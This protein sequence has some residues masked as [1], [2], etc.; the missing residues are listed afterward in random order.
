MALAS[1]TSTPTKPLLILVD[2]HSLAFRSYFAFAKGRDGGL[3]T[4]TGIPTSVSYGF[5]KALLETM[6]TEKPQYVA[7]AFD[8]G[9]KTF[10][11]EADETYKEGR[12][13][14]PED[15]MP[16]LENLQELLTALNLQILTMPR[17]EADDIIG[18]LVRKATANGFR[19]KILTGDRDLFQLIDPDQNTSVL[20]MSTTYGK[21]TPPPREF[22]AEQVKEKLGVLP[23][24]VVDFKALCGDASDNI[25]GVK[26]IGEKTAVQLLSEYGSLE[27]IYASLDQVKGAVRKKLEEGRDDALRSQYLAQIHLDVP[28]EI[29]LEAFK[30]QEMNDAAVIPLLE[31]LEFN[32][33]LNR[34][35]Q[36]HRQFDGNLTEASETNAPSAKSVRE[37]PDLWFFSAADTEAAQ[38]EVPV[39][40]APQ[41]IDTPA[42]LT[43]LIQRLKTFTNPDTPVSWDTETTALEP[44]DADLV[45]IGCCWG[46]ELSD[47]AYIP[48]GHTKGTNLDKATAL[49]ALRPILES[50]DYPK[51]LQNAKF[52]RLV[53]RCQ[54]IKL[55]GV[56]FD[57]MLASYVLNPESRHNLSDLSSA[58]L[59]ITAM[60]YT[61]LV[62]KGKAMADI[63][64]PA[65]A[66]YC[67]LDVYT[68]FLLVAKLRAKLEEVPTL[69]RL[70]LEVE[71]PLEP[72]LAEM[73]YCGVLI[74]R[75][76]L[77]HFS[78]QLEQDLHA[79]EQRAY[80]AAG[81]TFNLGSPKQ[82]SELLFETL[83]LD[84]KKSRK[85]AS[86]GYSTDAQTLER[87]EGDHPIIEEIVEYRTLSK[88]KSTYVDALPALIRPDTGRVHTD[89]NQAIASTGRLSSSDPNLQNIPIR[90]E[91]S[92]Q[93]RKAFIAEPEWVMVSADY[94]QIELRILAHLS[95]EPVLLET[96]QNN[97]DVHTLTARLLLEKENISSEE[98]RLA[99]IINFGVIY[100]MGAQRFA[101]ESGMKQADAKTFIER[102]NERYSNVFKYLQQMQREAIANGYVETILGRRRYFDFGSES[103]RKLR[104][105]KPDTIDLSKVKVRDQYD[106]Q[107]LRAAAN[108]PIQGSSADIIK[109]A[110]NQLHELI[111]DRQARLLLQVHDEL[112]FEMPPQ[113]WE[114]L[115]TEIKSTMESAVELTVPLLVEI[116]AGENWMEAK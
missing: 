98:R 102:F 20:Y 9:E 32:S 45:G 97:Q 57:T 105:T 16:D 24:Q 96:Y 69:H 22:G 2:G 113:E 101:R 58:Y 3:R 111:Q 18:T 72:V 93:I 87:L 68:T 115:Q 42:K 55:T 66:N 6:E 88:L 29:N 67:G 8:M 7:I 71:Q 109:V 108:A 74:D 51:A 92:R 70:L 75:D 64:I 56:V 73:E 62:P 49:E 65:V 99:K 53:F 36:L 13:E 44:R 39:A 21:G 17:Y 52:D 78:Q 116:R 63:D 104:G 10:R 12:P 35:R 114:A 46:E 50:A 15:F 54:G 28:I 61:D 37:D 95:Q 25:P 4:K 89:F 86:G 106:A 1:S 47:M 41:I 103:L 112:V 76:Y 43:E 90:T 48:L 38:K 80:E 107:S 33:L 23:S 91:F 60:S 30:L 77:K 26:G 110:M 34:I 82:L 5:L 100:G 79:I 11:H 31:K 85:T 94:S 27:Q 40:I 19:V 59:G 14:A 84:K 81:S 83:G